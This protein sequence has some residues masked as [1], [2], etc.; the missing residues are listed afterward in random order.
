M[1]KPFLKS[2]HDLKKNGYKV[3]RRLHRIENAD[4]ARSIYQKSC[5]Q[6]AFVFLS[7]F[8]L[9]NVVRD[10]MQLENKEYA[11]HKKFA[12]RTQK[13]VDILLKASTEGCAISRQV[14]VS[15]LKAYTKFFNFVKENRQKIMYNQ[16][17]HD[18]WSNKVVL[19]YIAT[20]GNKS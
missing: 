12:V 3:L 15:Y 2:T 19:A 1:I 16:A 5:K 13:L 4:A 17:I 11:E 20:W 8:H 6:G 7:V 10:S 14:V 9:A 18:E